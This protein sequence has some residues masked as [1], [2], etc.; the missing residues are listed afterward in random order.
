MFTERIGC[1]AGINEIP[2]GEFQ[3]FHATAQSV[4]ILRPRR[5]VKSDFERH[6]SFSRIP[7]KIDFVSLG[8]S[9]KK[10]LAPWNKPLKEGYHLIDDEGLPAHPAGR[11][12]IQHGRRINPEEIM[13]EARVPEIDLW[14]S[15]QSLADVHEIGGE[16]SNQEGLFQDINI[17]VD[18]VVTDP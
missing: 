7:E 17:A 4:R 6:D 3:I 13:Q 14:A 8:G 9:P 1:P 11:V 12:Y 2:A 18:G 16:L 5:R 15:Y 10:D